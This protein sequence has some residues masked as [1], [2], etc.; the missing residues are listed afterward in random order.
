MATFYYRATNSHGKVETGQ[1]E[2]ESK[3]KALEKLEKMGLFPILVSDKNQQRKEISLKGFDLEALL[4]SN[5]IS[6]AHVLDFTDKLA[7]L[8][9]AGLPLAKALRLLIDTTQ[10]TPMK[11]VIQRVLKDV[12]AGQS[13][14]ESLAKHPRVFGRL[15]INMVK[16]GETAGVLEKILFSLRDY[17]E[18]R[19]NLKSFLVSALIYPSILLLVGLGTVLV[20]VLFVLP[21]F[22]EVFDQ[23]G[24]ELP[25]ITRS[26]VDITNFLSTYKWLL[27][28]LVLIIWVWFSRW[29]STPEGRY[30]W[31]RFKLRAPVLKTIITEVE[32]TKFSNALGILLTSSVSLLEAMSIVRELFDNSV[33]IKAMEPAIKAV[34]RGDGMSVALSQ[35]KVFPKMVV[36]LITVGEETGTL[37]EMFQK[38]AGIYQQNIE[39]NIKRLLAMFEPV[40]IIAMFVVVGFI[41]AAMLLAVTSLSQAAI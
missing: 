39:R 8:L 4:P 36:H 24:Q 41:V 17:Q 22:Q 37:G 40:M 21:R 35:A 7:T 28:A 34:K 9:K 1:L 31:D 6:G 29:K 25:F 12:S 11:D 18:S 2:M 3:Q 20:L 26:L 16:T 14:A 19:Q 10:H 30:K 5:R 27:S 38:V 32:V 33:F 23:V 15:Y 13:F